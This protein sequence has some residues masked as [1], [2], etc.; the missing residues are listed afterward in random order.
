MLE[1]ISTKEQATSYGTI[2][3]I[4]ITVF[5]FIIPF[6]PGSN[7][8][9]LKTLCLFGVFSTI[10]SLVLIHKV[11]EVSGIIVSAILYGISISVLFTLA[12]TLRKEFNVKLKPS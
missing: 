11:D 5:R 2:Y 6:T 8:Q 1:K 10:V 7:S 12:Y 9:K 4:G 3:W